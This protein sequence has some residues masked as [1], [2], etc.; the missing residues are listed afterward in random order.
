MVRKISLALVLSGA[1]LVPVFSQQLQWAFSV[2]DPS[3]QN[4]GNHIA[5]NGS[6]FA[7]VASVSNNAN[8]DVA[9]GNPSFKGPANAMVKYNAQCGIEWV[10]EHP[11]G[12]GQYLTRLVYVDN[13]GN[14]YACGRFSGTV[15]FDPSSGQNNVTATNGAVYVQKLDSKGKL[16]WVGYTEV[17]G[18]PVK[19]D[20]KSNGNMVVVGRSQD[21]STPKLSGGGTV[22]VEKGVFILEF[23]SG[24]QSLNA[25]GIP[26][27][28]SF[29]NNL[30][31]AIDK[32][33]NVYVGAS[34]EGPM[35]LDLKN[36]SKADTSF[37]GYDAVLV[38]YNRHFDYVWHKVFGDKP[39]SGPDGWDVINSLKAGSDG[40]LYAAG[41]FTWVTDFDPDKNPGQ[42]VRT[43]STRSQSPDGFLIKYDT[44]GVIQWIQEAGG[45]P[46]ITGNADINFRE[47]VVQGGKIIVYGSINGS[48]DFDG[49]A[50]DYILKTA[51]NGLGICLAQYATDGSFTGAWLLDGNL[52]NESPSGMVLSGDGVVAYGTFQ[53][54]LD[55]DLT[56]GVQYLQT[57]STG[58]FY[59]FD[60]DLFLVKY[61]FGFA[62][63][64]IAKQS[65]AMNIQAYPNPATRQ[66]HLRNVQAGTPMRI[67][68]IQGMTVSRQEVSTE[69]TLDVSSLKPGVYLLH[70]GDGYREYTLRLVVQ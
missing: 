61:A 20:R 36:K 3:V 5:S 18:E 46:S 53:K 17:D 56:S 22:D 30:A 70:T 67:S 6:S 21:K 43:A 33:D 45:H 29:N 25:Y 69:N 14:V 35:N 24:G 2:K 55:V 66:V 62:P 37:S 7:V 27:P 31:L 48:A 40:F 38:K 13:D 8:Y 49:S 10:V 32:S 9:G 39:T 23:G 58:A 57:D 4:S 12:G 59:K 42:W 54:K 26:T 19:M 34:I 11:G 60:N 52:A 15:D 1:S 68:D 63:N 65:P 47:L 16:L 64:R 41:W 44:S 51:D 28:T 50:N